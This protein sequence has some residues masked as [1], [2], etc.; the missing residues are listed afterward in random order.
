MTRPTRA[1]EGT[2]DLRRL[3]SLYALDLLDHHDDRFERYGR[4]AAHAFDVPVALVTVLD[5]DRQW[6]CGAVGTELEGN[7][8]SESFCTELIDHEADMLVVGD[9]TTDTRFVELP[10]VAGEPHIRF[11]AGAS[12]AAPDGERLGTVCVLDV[13]PRDFDDRDRLALRDLADLVEQEILHLSLALTDTLTG[14]PNRRALLA[15]AERFLERAR[16]RHEPLSI[17]FV[18]VDGLKAVNDALGHARGDELLQRAAG[19]LSDCVRPSD[20]VARLGG[21]EFAIL[22]YGFDAAAAATAIDGLRTMVAASNLQR[23][24]DEPQ[25]ALSFGAATARDDATLDDVIAEADAAMYAA[26]AARRDSR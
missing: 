25:V 8:R 14:L 24:P 20:L 7:R 22:M 15:A 17:V 16:R 21:D 9:S 4:V 26:R 2:D 12:V 19:V 13:E 5:D 11:Y 18:D 23:S 1:V 3:R 10:I 6:F